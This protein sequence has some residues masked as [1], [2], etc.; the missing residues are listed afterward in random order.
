M[1][2]EERQKGS[3]INMAAFLPVS[4]SNG[5]GR[6]A[7]VWVQGCGRNCPGCFNQD[8]QVFADK[9]LIAPEELAERILA[10]DGIEGVTFSGG[11]PFA[12]AEALAELAEQLRAC[13]LNIVIF[14][15]YTFA[16]L[17][18]GRNLA[19]QRLLAVTDL[20]VAGPYEQGLPSQDY[21]RASVNQRLLFLTDK[22]MQH[23]DVGDNNHG[24][25]T[26]VIVDAAGKVII[27]G[28]GQIF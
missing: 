17:S 13:G 3:L 26:E 1:T 25:I 14:S 4:R 9:Q 6:R 5:P 27:T 22:L 18:T 10:I 28:L 21:L 8:M 20:L 16:E 23:P 24:Q 19:W 2:G 11:E 7:V 12:Q 15:G